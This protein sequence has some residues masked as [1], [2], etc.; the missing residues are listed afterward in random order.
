MFCWEW[1]LFVLNGVI[2]SGVV[3]GVIDK[4]KLWIIVVRIMCIW[5][6]VMLLLG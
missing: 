5:N 1:N 2:D 3:F 6:D 4:W